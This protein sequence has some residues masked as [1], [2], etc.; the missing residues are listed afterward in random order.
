MS[1]LDHS[2]SFRIVDFDIPYGYPFIR[3][4]IRRRL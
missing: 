2:R 3:L 4:S 1:Y